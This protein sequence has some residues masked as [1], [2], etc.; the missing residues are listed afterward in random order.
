[1][2]TSIEIENLRGIAQGK[3]EGLAPLTVLTGPNGC[4]KSTV[5]DAAY[6]AGGPY[7]TALERVVQRRPETLYGAR[8]IVGRRGEVAR[9]VVRGRGGGQWAGASVRLESETTHHAELAERGV[10]GPF[11]VLMYATQNGVA[12]YRQAYSSTFGPKNEAATRV[13]DS[14]E[15]KV[16]GAMHLV[17]PGIAQPLHHAYSDV[18][19][20]GQKQA[21]GE[22]I[23]ALLPAFAGFDILAE[24]DNQPQLYAVLQDGA[25]PLGLMGDGVQGLAHV[26]LELARAKGGTVLIEEPEVYQH[27]RAL[28][29]TAKAI[30][31]A[32][33]RGT[34]VIL[35][36]HSLE[37][38]DQLVEAGAGQLDKMALFNL[39][40]DGGKLL[41]ARWSG[42]DMRYAR[43][44][45]GNDL[46]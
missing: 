35:T 9:V 12:S 32:V 11:V 14:D 4:G 28:Q 17:D 41:Y 37:L 18:V 1:L 43:E 27:P 7:R 29:Q 16:W 10:H 13:W 8:W 2:I 44:Q 42:D 15:R 36:T 6:L 45:V 19:R 30:H 24:P 31:A 3:L 21:I 34:Q 26:V 25:V 38:I 22:L 39:K 5:L 20:A 40:L 33:A 46:R 23:S